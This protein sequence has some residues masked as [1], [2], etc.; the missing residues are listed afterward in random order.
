M[1][2]AYFNYKTNN[3]I[4]S[5]YHGVHKNELSILKKEATHFR[6]NQDEKLMRIQETLDTFM[7]EVHAKESAFAPNF[8]ESDVEILRNQLSTLESLELNVV[9]D[10]RFLES[11]R[12]HRQ[13]ERHTLIPK[14][15]QQT[16]SWILNPSRTDYE[17]RQLYT[18]LQK[19][20]RGIFWVSGKPGSGKSTL[21]K[22]VADNEETKRVLSAWSDGKKLIV[23]SYYFWWSGTALQ[24]SQEGLLRTLL[25]SIF[26]QCPDLIRLARDGLRASSDSSS[27]EEAETGASRSWTTEEL[28][29]VIK[30]VASQPDLPVK[31]CFFIDGLDEYDGDHKEICD[32]FKVLVKESSGIKMCL[33]S[34]PWNVFEQAL[35]NKSNRI[36]IHDLTQQDVRNFAQSRLS[37]HLQWQTMSLENPEVQN[38]VKEVTKRAQGVFLWVFLVTGL[39]CEGLNNGDSLSDLKLRL[40]SFPSDL[41]R[42]YKDILEKVDDFYHTK[43]STVLRIALAAEEPLALSLYAFH[44]E[45]FENIDYAID[46]K[47]GIL[48][49]E[50]VKIRHRVMA[51]R[52][53]GWAKGLVEVRNEEVH[54]LHRTVVD[55]LRTHEMEEFIA[56]RLPSW[57]CVDL[58]I[59]KAHLAWIKTS[60]FADSFP[61]PQSATTATLELRVQE[62]LRWAFQ[63]ENTLPASSPVHDAS[64]IILD[65][66]ERSIEAQSGS[67]NV[68]FLNEREARPKQNFFRNSVLHSYLAGYLSRKLLVSPDYF[69][70]LGKPAIS[71]LLEPVTRKEKEDSWPKGWTDTLLCLL[72]SGQDPNQKYREPGDCNQDRTPWKEFLSTVI[73]WDHSKRSPMQGERFVGAM[74][75]GIFSLFLEHG[76]SPHALTLRTGGAIPVFSTVWADML[77]VSFEVSSKRA[78]EEDYLQELNAFLS[79]GAKVNAASKGTIVSN[80]L[81]SNGASANE[82][83]FSQLMP[84]IKSGKCNAG[85]LERVTKI[86]LSKMQDSSIPLDWALKKVSTA[87]APAKVQKL[88]SE[89][90]VRGKAIAAGSN[91][92]PSG[93][94]KRR[95]M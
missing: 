11:L 72:R 16:F 59:L 39:L 57:F 26:Q 32:I 10:R 94:G 52:L 40:E 89:L 55:F 73:D 63:L 21:M 42:F 24:K 9:M 60:N 28:H 13:P 84:R 77:L 61:A 29:S 92:T 85:L 70:G 95:K 48:S 51:Q 58:S 90:E 46:K 65:D 18:W 66:M 69:Q 93:G 82:A 47:V 22:F 49:N 45:E 3:Q 68:T 7:F 78:D 5:Y 83:F 67:G 33:S 54:F 64:G 43:V 88:C 87:L 50:A 20:D 1:F 2:S 23:A 6:L 38:L 71:M 75:N 31:F 91:R 36:Y 44:E 14:A 27:L 19:K 34:R 25:Y 17:A 86:L 30:T 81:V 41:E 8:S 15:H 53:N 74:H 79:H 76:A 56:G 62:A 35:G 37:N 4:H 12:F 80:R